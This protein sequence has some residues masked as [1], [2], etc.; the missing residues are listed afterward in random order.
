MFPKFV[1]RLGKMRVVLLHLALQTA[2]DDFI[3]V[4]TGLRKRNWR[5]PR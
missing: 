1:V 2:N 4:G 3:V 5:V